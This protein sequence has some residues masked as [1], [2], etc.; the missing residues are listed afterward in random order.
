MEF[1]T[2][3]GAPGKGAIGSLPFRSFSLYTVCIMDVRCRPWVRVLPPFRGWKRKEVSADLQSS[4]CGRD[5]KY[6]NNFFKKL[7]LILNDKGT[8]PPPPLFCGSGDEIMVLC[9]LGK[10]STTVHPQT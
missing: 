6:G 10:R 1:E 9:T 8:N 2:G 4:F 3:V 7:F 5:K